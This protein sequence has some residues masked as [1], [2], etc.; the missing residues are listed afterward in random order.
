V[1]AQPT[2][3]ENRKLKKHADTK[4]RNYMEL[5][6]VSPRAARLSAFLSRNSVAV[7]PAFAQCTSRSTRRNIIVNDQPTNMATDDVIKPHTRIEKESKCM[8]HM[9]ASESSLFCLEAASSSSRE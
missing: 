8:F 7:D 1:N 2:K 9:F 4:I 6:K 5:L 3:R